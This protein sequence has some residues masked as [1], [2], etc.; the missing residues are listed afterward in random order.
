MRRFHLLSI[1]SVVVLSALC[2]LVQRTLAQGSSADETKPEVVLTELSP[3]VY[4]P[5]A[6]AARITGDVELQLLIRKDGVVD[7]AQVVSGHPLLRQ[8]AVD[9]AQKSQ[10][11]CRGCQGITTYFLTYT[12]VIGDECHNAPDCSAVGERPPEIR[13]W[14]NHVAVT[15]DPWCTCD[16]AGEITRIRW[17]S[18]RC[19][20]LWRC[21]SRV[22]ESRWIRLL[23]RPSISISDALRII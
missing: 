4:P 16:P 11:E 9:S 10:F 3:P 17:R 8:A 22:I 7:T 12:F 14:P 15:V 18:A 6:R 2:G 19:L 5:L 1:L 13:H 20:Y 21:G 23:P